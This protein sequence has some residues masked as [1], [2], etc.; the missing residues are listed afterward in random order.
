ME[1][2]DEELQGGVLAIPETLSQLSMLPSEIAAPPVE[3]AMQSVEM[4]TS[5]ELSPE[6]LEAMPGY[7]TGDD[8][9]EPV[10]EQF[11]FE[12]EEE[13]FEQPVLEQPEI[14]DD[15][16]VAPHMIESETA[17]LLEVWHGGPNA[18]E[19]YTGDVVDSLQEI[20]ER[21]PTSP[22][23]ADPAQASLEFTKGA[24]HLFFQNFREGGC[25]A[26]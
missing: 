11:V 5:E 15:A 10:G 2:D 6:A 12:D 7:L 24:G 22:L 26:R 16:L 4:P 19:E 8:M 23:T 21:D 3:P 13:V 20:S 1:R 17:G 25:A 9:P 14:P 18:L